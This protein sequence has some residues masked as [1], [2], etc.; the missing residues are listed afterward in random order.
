M[1]I[2][3]CGIQF[4]IRN[5]REVG[6]D[7]AEQERVREQIRE[8]FEELRGRDLTNAEV[9][10]EAQHLLAL[11]EPAIPVILERFTDEDETLLAVATQALKVWGEPRPVE[12]LLTLLRN[13]DVSDLAKALIL[14]VLEK[15]G[16]DVDDPELLGLSIDLEDYQVDSG[17]DG[18][19]GA[20]DS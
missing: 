10:V 9:D 5:Q 17:G 2:A 4:E 15:Y 13:P 1:R 18:G 8:R 7:S 3:E 6:M 12:P 16:L 19:N 11:G 14:N 20:R